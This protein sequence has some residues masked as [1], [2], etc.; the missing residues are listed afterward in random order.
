MTRSGPSSQ[1]PWGAL[2]ARLTLGALDPLHCPAEV[3]VGLSFMPVL[4]GW[5][6]GGRH[7]CCPVRTLPRVA[8]LDSQCLLQALRPGQHSGPSIQRAASSSLHFEG[9]PT[10]NTRLQTQA[11]H[12]SFHDALTP[13]TVMI[14]VMSVKK[15]FENK[16]PSVQ[17]AEAVMDVAHPVSVACLTW[18][19][20][21]CR[22]RNRNPVP[23]L[24]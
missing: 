23:S 12:S 9:H 24:G 15:H 4:V 6:G 8:R 17:H 10:P 19:D 20:L 22:P 21:R 16:A 1:G 5:V 7:I 2:Q 3:R 14:E 18:G 13:V 11:L